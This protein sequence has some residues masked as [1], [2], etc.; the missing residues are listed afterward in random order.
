MKGIRSL[1]LL[2]R[3]QFDLFQSQ[4]SSMRRE[5]SLLGRQYHRRCRTQDYQLTERRVAQ[6]YLVNTDDDFN[7]YVNKNRPREQRIDIRDFFDDHQHKHYHE[8]QACFDR[9]TELPSQPKMG[10][11]AKLVNFNFISLMF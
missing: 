7:N 6:N 5:V 11:L 9:N 4:D 3:I 10:V 2:C 8:T 1:S